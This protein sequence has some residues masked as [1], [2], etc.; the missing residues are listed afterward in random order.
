MNIQIII[1]GIGGQ[2]VLFAT[3]VLTE[4]ALARGANLI[5]SE[6]HGMSQ[7]GGSVTSHLKIGRFQ[8][9][10]V[11][12]GAAD[13]LYGFEQ[14]EFLRT[15]PFIKNGGVCFIN[16]SKNTLPN[17]KLQKY[18]HKHGIAIFYLDADKIA[19]ELGA[20]LSANLVML[21]Y[22][23]ALLQNTRQ[24]IFF[25]AAEMETTI[26]K[27][28]PAQLLEINLKAFQT[29]LSISGKPSQD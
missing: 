10:L 14:T 5:G 17:E 22:S 29:G 2:G 3:K 11:R 26:K 25:T 24:N 20:P 12:T 28:S 7:R 27:I 15:L 8:S 19:L 18:C 23:T 9:P 6:T 13:I 1:S 16:T 21:G 4:T